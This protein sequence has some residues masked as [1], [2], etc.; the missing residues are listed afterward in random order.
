M[1]ISVIVPTYNRPEELRVFIKSILKQTVLPDELIII[2][3]GNLNDIPEKNAL[4]NLNISCVYRKKCK[5][6][7]RGVVFSRNIGIEMTTGDIIFLLED[8]LF[9]DDR[10][11]ENI[12][13][14]Y[15]NSGFPNIGGVGGIDLNMGKRNFLKV[16]EYIFNVFFLISPVRPYHTTP[17]G[18]SENVVTSVVWKLYEKDKVVK[19]SYLAG[20]NSAFPKEV[21]KNYRFPED[22]SDR[23][24]MGE[25]KF[26][27]MNISKK[28][29]LYIVTKSKFYHNKSKLMRHNK[30]TV[31]YNTV[32]SA[33]RIYVNYVKKFKLHFLL[34]LY[35]SLGLLLKRFIIACFRFKRYEFNRVKGILKGIYDAILLEINKD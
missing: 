16:L 24:Y 3:D 13:D 23:V 14:F 29:N 18:Y 20:G 2:D 21:L 5:S 32:M 19:T 11:I 1:K 4:M 28:Y 6:E 12:I 9:L 35:S 27:S 34:F 25:D 30:Y 10:Y 17:S 22:Y 31:G 7:K 15:K 26:F 33:Y 8:D